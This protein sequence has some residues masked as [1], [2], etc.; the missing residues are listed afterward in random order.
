MADATIL[1]GVAGGGSVSG[2]S[3]ALIASQLDSIINSLSQSNRFKVKVDLD[4]SGTQTSLNN[5]L[6]N[7]ISS[8]NSGNKLNLSIDKI[9]ANSAINNVR[10]QLQQM[11]K[12]LNT[13]N[14]STNIA[15]LL[16][17]ENLT[18]VERLSDAFNQVAI[19]ANQANQAITRTRSATLSNQM[20]TWMN[21][22]TK[23]AQIYGDELRRLQTLL[24]GNINAKQLTA[25]RAEFGRI[26][27][28]AAAAGLT[29]SQFAQSIKNVAMQVL[30]LTSA[31]MV[32]RRLI[33]EIKKGVQTVTEL[34]TAL[35]DL[36]KTTTMSS[37]DLPAFYK[38]ANVAAKELGT[39]TKDIIQSAADWSRLGFSDKKSSENMAKLS[40][41]FSAIS[42][43]VDIKNAT[44]GLLS[45]MKTYGIEV[46]DVLDGIMSKINIVGNT[47]GTS[48]EQ[49][50]NGLQHS[51]SALSAMGS[52]LEENIALFTAAQEIIQND[53]KVGNA[54]RTITMRIR[55]YDEETEQLSDDLANI[56]GE[57]IDL[58]KTASN[59]KGI[60]LFTDETQ[61]QYK[62]IYQ[63]LKDISEIY[64]QLGAKQ[65]QALM[66]KLFGKMRS[67]VGQAI[68]QNFSAAEKA[69]DNMANSAG[70]ADAEMSIITESLEYKFNALKE[71]GTGILQDIFPREQISAVVGVLTTV[72]EAINSITT[73]LGPLGSILVLGTGIAAFIKNLSSL[74]AIGTISTV[75]GDIATKGAV[76]AGAIK[77]VNTAMTG[78][79]ASTGAATASTLSYMAAQT[80]TA[81][82]AAGLTVEQI[83]ANMAL[84]GFTKEAT[85]AALAARGFAA[86]ERDAA[87]ASAEASIGFAAAGVKAQTATSGLALAF[88]G[89][90]S[91]IKAHPVIAAITTIS[92]GI[93][94]GFNKIR[95]ANEAADAAARESGSIYNDQV[96]SIEN[97]RSKITEL[98]SE[99][100]SG[101]LSTEEAYNKREELLGIQDE[102]CSKLGSEAGAFNVLHDSIDK[103]NGVLEQYN[104]QQANNLLTEN[105]AAYRRAA[106]KMEKKQD[107]GSSNENIIFADNNRWFSKEEK[108]ARD[109]VN[110]ILS[111]VFSSDELSFGYQDDGDIYLRFNVDARRAKEGIQEIVNEMSALENELNGRGLDLNKILGV[112]SWRGVFS[113][114]LGEANKVI[115]DFGDMYD[116]YVQSLI[117]TDNNYRNLMTQTKQ[118]IDDFKKAQAD[119]NENAMVDAY[120]NMA[121]LSVQFVNIEDESV[122]QYFENVRESFDD[123][124][125]DQVM[126]INLKTDLKANTNTWS[127]DIH[128]ALEKFR[129]SDG[130]IDADDIL[131]VGQDV[132]SY[133]SSYTNFT[134]QEQAYKDLCTALEHYGLTAEEVA[135]KAIPIFEELGLVVSD[136]AKNLSDH[137]EVPKSYE[138]LK[139]TADAAVGSMNTLG[140]VFFNNTH[141]TEDAYNN[142]VAFAD[143]EQALADC[144]DTANGY[145]VT[146]AEALMAVVAASEDAA[147]SKVK[148]ARAHEEA[149]YHS[150]VSALEEVC[151]VTD[152]FN[153]A[154]SRTA[155]ILLEQID[156][157]EAQIS[158][159]AMLEQ[160]LLGVTNA[161]SKMESARAA[162][163]V[164]DYTDEASSLI[165][166]LYN[167]FENNEFG[168]SAFENAFEGLIPEN[169][170][171]QFTGAASEIEAGWSYLENKLSR[172]FTRENG[173][174][175][176][177]FD[178]VK[179]FVSDALNT[180]Y[181]G[182]TV[183][184]GTLED[185]DLNPNIKSL[186]QFA[187]AL[188]LTTEMAFTLASAISKYNVDGDDL[189]SKFGLD[190]LESKIMS[191]EREMAELLE[192]KTKLGKEGKVGTDEWDK[193]NE[194]IYTAKKNLSQL[195]EDSAVNIIA[196]INVDSQV[197]AKQAEV[198]QLKA[199]LDA[200]N[201]SDPKYTTTLTNY[202]QA[203]SEL[204]NLQRQLYG[205]EEP[206]ELTCT[207][208]LE[209]INSQI[210][211]VKTRLSQIANYDTINNVYVAIDQADVQEVNA[212]N[213]QLKSLE[214]DKHTIEAYVG[215]DSDKA[216]SKVEE[217]RDLEIKD[218]KFSVIAKVGNTLP[219]LESIRNALKSINSK[220]ITVTTNYV[221]NGSPPSTGAST[222]AKKSSYNYAGTNSFGHAAG[223][224]LASGNW[225]TKS[226]EHNALVGELGEELVVDPRT[227]RYY[228]VGINGAELVDLPAG[229]IV[230]NH[231]QTAEI[232]RHRHIDTR[233]TALVE[234]NAHLGLYDRDFKS[235][236][237]TKSKSKSGSSSS[238]KSSSPSYSS[239][240]S[241]SSEKSSSE[242]KI[243]WEEELK[244]YQHLRKME[245]MADEEYYSKLNDLIARYAYVKASYIDDYRSLLEESYELQRSLQTDWFNDREHEITLLEK[246]G[247][248]VAKLI[249]AYREVRA[250]TSKWANEAR[251]YGLSD[252]SDFI[253]DMQ[254]RYWEAT[255]AIEELKQKNYEN[256]VKF[257][258]AQRDNAIS[259]EAPEKVKEA[260][261]E[262][263][264]LSQ[265]RQEELHWRA[266]SLRDSGASEDSEAIR[267][268][269]SQWWELNETIKDAKNAE[270]EFNVATKESAITLNENWRN[271]AVAGGGFD[272]ATQYTNEIIAN[273]KAQQDLAHQQA[274]YLRSIGY[275]DTSEEVAELSDK[276]WELNEAVIEAKKT[277]YEYAV[278]ARENAITLN[279][280]WRDNA[281]ADRDFD[282]VSKY[283]DRIIASLK[284]QQDLAHQQAD[285][286]RDNGYSDTSDEVSELSNK[287]WELEDSI[288]EAKQVVVD[289]LLEIV[290]ASNEAVDEIQNV[291]D[292][293]K[294][295]AD[296]YAANEGYISVDTFQS[297]IELG[298]EYMQYL[299]DE[300]G[301]L[302]INEENIQKVIAA[303]TKQL[304]LDNAL[305]YVERLRLAMQ[306]GSIEDLNQLLTATTKATDATWGL[307]YA[308]LKLVGLD[309]KQYQIALHNINSIRSLADNAA[310]GIGKVGESLEDKL[311]DM[312]DGINDIINYVMDMRRDRIEEQIKALED[313]KDTYSDLID[314]R[315]ENLDVARQERKHEEDVA[316][317][318]KEIAKLQSKIDALSL[319]NSRDAQAKKASL[320]EEMSELQKDL[321]DTQEEYI[322]D[323]QK[324]SLEDMKD[325]YDEEKD[326][327]IGAL[328]ESIS[329]KQKLYDK[330]L[331]YISENWKDLYD[332]LI[333][334]NTEM[335]NSLNDDITESWNKALLAADRYG[336]GVKEILAGIK[337]DKEAI[338]DYVIVGAT[339]SYEQDY[340]SGYAQ[341]ARV[342]VA[343]M[344]AL[345]SQWHTMSTKEDKDA[346]HTESTK[347][348]LDLAN[349]GISTRYDDKTGIWYIE[350]DVNNP[351][352][353]G[354]PLFNVYSD[355]GVS[356]PD[357]SSDKSTGKTTTRTASEAKMVRNIV[358]IMKECASQ[359][360]PTMSSEEK[361]NLHGVS[362]D[363][364]A[365]LVPYG[366]EA[367]YDNKTGIWTVKRDEYVP[368]NKGK[369][370]FDV[371]HEGGIAGDIG[372]LKENELL[373]KLETGETIIPIRAKNALF[374]TIDMVSMLSKKLDVSGFMTDGGFSKIQEVAEDGYYPDPSIIT[375]NS[376]V[377]PSIHFGDVIIY[378][379]NESTVKKHQE[380]SR[381]MADEVLAYIRPRR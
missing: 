159:Y 134:A 62:S 86:A 34:D 276:W 128:D 286:L 228:T 205:L 271:N 357:K 147:L 260:T 258:E 129:K 182:S 334:W 242:D 21:Q 270:Y 77:A 199:S 307:V 192:K 217:I 200:L 183:L 171:G 65:Q 55:G 347:K 259:I 358:S 256:A 63:Y 75:I 170:A 234:G 53:S 139:K 302:V 56:S 372:T 197:Q 306:E 304:A 89:L 363:Q 12:V 283:N 309:D 324:E 164:M 163:E 361:E 44:T 337:A 88:N 117:M 342:I 249:E 288:K 290:D 374:R 57:V 296:D 282:K 3:G 253:Q 175:T 326:D 345:A 17:L 91:T 14:N 308:N 222:G 366:I 351:D 381:K 15:K 20:T 46:E 33:S 19:S 82:A 297:I 272:K 106:R 124:A 143:S 281:I 335:G 341:R 289:S 240:K 103:V 277:G 273:L 165:D 8:L 348:T 247:A 214:A 100:D 36:K 115:D 138:E 230:F 135:G 263:I 104:I 114:A 112:T 325:A 209:N 323:K 90:V 172:Y 61:T 350:N 120:N 362:V 257:L 161:F 121:Q 174:T 105:N 191:C 243:P 232:L 221:Q 64:D 92:A 285:F 145:L 295:A 133:D 262:I 99:L 210:D 229:A 218:K 269:S 251:E 303:K 213:N 189:I 85:V 219:T 176:I 47:A 111:K 169:I 280:N 226:F 122:K 24:N 11:L 160:Q 110:A 59:P 78:L 265:A 167:G 7:I 50:I 298:P 279:E 231:K 198:D 96:S 291:Y 344:K 141:I 107:F 321:S 365:R 23:A 136:T 45:V 331:D 10:T 186:E 2:E 338:E 43:G 293:L 314:L 377:G 93:I 235:S 98:R 108:A 13:S 275:S 266:Q 179:N 212:L 245:L 327:E 354:K 6:K 87:V 194:Q 193:L 41:Q 379:G 97:Y 142:L 215:V 239:S 336:E 360:E 188:G 16:G 225:G 29:T 355:G 359:W 244:E 116:T 168:T 51:A 137:Y 102:I 154:N 312:E 305:T 156:A 69:M 315:K 300:G 30:G 52:S 201:K 123:M 356:V 223:T 250:Q 364:A 246:N 319:D 252:D 208:S 81:L 152:V 84:M 206:T 71:T 224:A 79:S 94:I 329:S 227:G 241:S 144:I 261:D 187:D 1:V 37:A 49:I 318:I 292:T 72:L 28:E 60:S 248:S 294:K 284:A 31:S 301:M 204:E 130:T 4:V 67:D 9:D 54:I 352:N 237:S 149:N 126:E 70:N 322:L 299:E 378:G 184:Q 74:K 95:E 311:D 125:Q 255:E 373:A 162:D 148:M 155:D 80:S 173:K 371:Y 203:K 18:G 207:L 370:L 233:G 118:Y 109:R 190:T 22:N 40:A 216:K 313:L 202:N 317:K 346:L 150:L 73:A 369:K 32:I 328:K 157:V 185:F 236:A 127:K 211:N 113:G 151:D 330:A 58:T 140:E 349:L 48:N 367:E 195:K 177:G 25:I 267:D 196:Y 146:N 83:A 101:S 158:K 178:N 368:G 66:E 181:D 166:E 35:V 42:P 353:N 320:L 316:D 310:A 264:R 376:T 76:S 333:A 375:N 332:E 180:A 340:T 119:D 254:N 339:Q 380:I 131:R 68:L 268:L 38:D 238:S 153:E 274:D 278:S 343:E 132:A 27:S 220:N 26:K 39:T 287:Y 5:S